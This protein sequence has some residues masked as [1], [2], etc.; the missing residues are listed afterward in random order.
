MCCAYRACIVLVEARALA[1]STYSKSKFEKNRKIQNNNNNNDNKKSRPTKRE[2][3]KQHQKMFFFFFFVLLP[4]FCLSPPPSLLS[5]SACCRTCIILHHINSITK[6]TKHTY[7]Y[8]LLYIFNGVGIRRL[9]IQS[10]YRFGTTCGVRRGCCI[11]RRWRGKNIWIHL[12]KRIVPP[13]T[14]CNCIFR[15]CRASDAD[16]PNKIKNEWKKQERKQYRWERTRIEKKKKKEKKRSTDNISRVLYFM[17]CGFFLI[18]IFS[19]YKKDD[20]SYIL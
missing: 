4:F 18:F 8:I 12:A 11:K 10:L 1:P 17:L 5:L 16:D 9:W 3:I 2:K 6:A 13:L 7:P 19:K 20:S 14:L 15:L